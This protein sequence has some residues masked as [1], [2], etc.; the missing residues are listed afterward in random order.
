LSDLTADTAE[1]VE[2]MRDGGNG[3]TGA[4]VDFYQVL[5]LGVET[6]IHLLRYHNN[7]RFRKVVESR[8]M[9]KG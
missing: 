7:L 2:W 6:Q 5:T 4:F 9:D 1:V 8:R 3:A